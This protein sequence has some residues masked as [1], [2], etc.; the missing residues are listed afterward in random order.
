MSELS[1]HAMQL[2]ITHPSGAEEWA[3]AECGRRILM[4]WPPNYKRTVLEAGDEFAIHSGGKG[5]LML[6]A[7]EVSDAPVVAD[8]FSQS[9]WADWLEELD[10][11]DDAEGDEA[12]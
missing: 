7:P 6:T 8:E 3:C 5:G 10:F 4:Q 11:G 1:Q 2:E 9:P 12:E